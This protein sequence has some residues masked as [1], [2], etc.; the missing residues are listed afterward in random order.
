MNSYGVDGT[1]PMTDGSIGNI[2]FIVEAKTLSEATAKA[3]S[4]VKA[5]EDLDIT[6]WAIYELE[7]E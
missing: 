6:L 2:D 5:I 3:E 4:V 1:F 7:A